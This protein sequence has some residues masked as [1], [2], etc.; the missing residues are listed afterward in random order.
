MH[1]TPLSMILPSRA[2]P[3]KTIPQPTSLEMSDLADRCPAFVYTRLSEARSIRLLT[4]LPGT[5]DSQAPLRCLLSEVSL[6]SKPDYEALSYTWATEDGNRSTSEQVI[7][8]EC[9]ILITRNCEAALRRVRL[10]EERRVVWVDAICI[11]QKD[12]GE[13][14]QQVAMMGDIYR[15]TRQ[16]LVWLGHGSEHIYGALTWL[17]DYAVAE[18]CSQEWRSDYLR[19]LVRYRFEDLLQVAG[20]LSMEPVQLEQIRAQSPHG[21]GVDAMNA[22]RETYGPILHSKTCTFENR[23]NHVVSEMKKDLH[24]QRLQS[25]PRWS[26]MR[27]IFGFQ[28]WRRIWVLQETALPVG[29]VMYCGSHQTN[30][31]RFTS[32]LPEELR[33]DIS[34]GHRF[35]AH[36]YFR[37]L[38]QKEEPPYLGMSPM[39]DPFQL[40]LVAQTSL[41]TNARDKIYGILGL[42]QQLYRRQDLLPPPDYNKSVA[43]LFTDVACRLVQF[44]GHASLIVGC[45]GE[46]NS[47]R[48]PSWVPDWSQPLP[49]SW[50]GQFSRLESTIGFK[51][52]REGQVKTLSGLIKPEVWAKT[53]VLRMY[54]RPFCTVDSVWITCDAV[55]PLDEAWCQLFLAWFHLA[56]SQAD[57]CRV[58]SADEIFSGLVSAGEG[59]AFTLRS[60]VDDYPQDFEA[61]CRAWIALL[62]RTN[63]YDVTRE[64]R[65]CDEACRIQDWSVAR[66]KGRVACLTDTGHVGLV[67]QATNVKDVVVSIADSFISMPYVLRS[68]GDQYKAIGACYLFGAMHQQGPMIG[69][70]DFTWMAIR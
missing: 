70:A 19:S 10:P 7:V 47:Y 32:F 59:E 51:Y 35:N 50:N 8:N 38:I 64:T 5:D 68:D 21:L 13:V 3:P 62:L 2:R 52:I 25:T 65:A 55:D 16:T 56:Q 34:S 44:T 48:L 33:W 17:N 40:L 46:E 18:S 23:C 63:V 29:V 30:Y 4:L 14:N 58:V 41:A 15:D 53:S 57:V 24:Q 42:F 22:I 26:A 31:A 28:W 27:K 61:D 69:D 60:Y 54:A 49:W 37:K 66:T 12:V 45:T 39:P 11:D 1:C 67:P 9:F 20:E 6:D 36:L 43:V